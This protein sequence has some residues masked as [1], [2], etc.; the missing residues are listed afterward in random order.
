MRISDW[1]SDVCSS[2]L[3]RTCCNGVCCCRPGVVWLDLLRNWSLHEHEHAAVEC[4][5]NCISDW[6]D[7]RADHEP[8]LSTCHLILQRH[9]PAPHVDDCSWDRATC[10]QT[11][12]GSSPRME[13]GFTH[14]AHF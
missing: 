3:V 1:S 4:I 12:P 5:G 10:L 9:E 7:L 2:D 6:I 13:A 14:P 8:D 11:G